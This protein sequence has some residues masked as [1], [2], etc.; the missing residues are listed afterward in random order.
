MWVHTHLPYIDWTPVHTCTRPQDLIQCT[1][2]KHKSYP[3]CYL[4]L[5]RLNTFPLNTGLPLYTTDLYRCV[6]PTRVPGYSPIKHRPTLYWDDWPHYTVFTW[7]QTNWTP[8]CTILLYLIPLYYVTYTSL[9]EY[10]PVEHRPI[11]H[12]CF[13]PPHYNTGKLTNCTLD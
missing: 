3:P 7:P 8:A 1:Y 4:S 2:L 10:K 9:P 11:L 5:T 13:T 12:Y 6:H